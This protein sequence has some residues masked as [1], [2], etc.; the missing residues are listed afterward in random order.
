MNNYRGPP[1]SSTSSTSTANTSF[2]N[3]HHQQQPHQ[4]QQHTQLVASD[5][6]GLLQLEKR[7]LDKLDR[8]KQQQNNNQHNNFPYNNSQATNQFVNNNNNNTNNYSTISHTYN[9]TNNNINNQSNIRTDRLRELNRQQTS[10]LS[11]SQAI[12]KYPQPTETRNLVSNGYFTT[13]NN[14]N[15]SDSSSGYSSA[16]NNYNTYLSNN[17]AT[18]KN[19]N[20]LLGDSNSTVSP[21]KTKPSLTNFS[22]EEAVNS[23]TLDEISALLS[24]GS[25]ISNGNFISGVGVNNNANKLLNDS[26][27]NLVY[28]KNFNLNSNDFLKDF[29]DMSKTT[30]NWKSSFAAMRDKFGSAEQNGGSNGNVNERGGFMANGTSKFS[31]NTTMNPRNQFVE[32]NSNNNQ[33][34]NNSDSF[35]SSQ[36]SRYFFTYIWKNYYNIEICFCFTIR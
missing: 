26:N 16:N 9:N 33:N 30:N 31:G 11:A 5:Y 13:T 32:N 17:T 8:Q 34:S 3:P 18:N 20:R 14:N 19:I 10:Y 4:H 1:S 15:S 28:G 7:I 27:N 21:S 25:F 24:S 6:G 29:E 23:L 2:N 36:Y 35:T 12:N 22:D